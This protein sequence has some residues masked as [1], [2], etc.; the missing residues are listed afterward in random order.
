MAVSLKYN[1][2][3]HTT[4]TVQEWLKEHDKEFK[5]L[6]P[7]PTTPPTRSKGSIAN[8][9][10]PNTTA[11]TQRCYIYALMGFG[12]KKSYQHNMRQVV[13]TLQ[14][15]CV[16]QSRCCSRQTVRFCPLCHYVIQFLL[17]LCTKRVKSN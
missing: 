12:D 9:H 17:L 10:L 13:F 5:M 3:C 2:F 6:T 7:D 8:I 16:S 1:V 4:K 15:I 11:H 14:W